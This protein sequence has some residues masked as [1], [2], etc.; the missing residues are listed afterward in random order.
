MINKEKSNNFYKSLDQLSQKMENIN[1]DIE[2][3]KK[4][5]QN[6]MNIMI[7]RI[8]HISTSVPK[9]ANKDFVKHCDSVVKNLKESLNI[10]SKKFEEIL[11]KEEFRNEFKDSFLV[12]IYGKVKAGKSSFGNYIAKQALPSQKAK[13]FLYDKA[14]QIK[15]TAK[16]EEIDSDS[17]F[18][19]KR[20]EATTEIQGFRLSGLTWIDTPG[21]ASMSPENGELAKEY[22]ESAD[23]I[24]YPISSDAP[25]RSTDI[26]EIVELFTKNKKVNILITKSD[27][28]SRTI[29]NGKIIPIIKNKTKEDRKKQEEYVL[30]SIKSNLPKINQLLIDDNIYSLSTR[31]A[32]IGI[33]T[34]NE[35]LYNES[36][37]DIFYEHMT[38]LLNGQAIQLKT[39]APLDKLK[40]F[41][42]FHII[43]ENNDESC[44]TLKSIQ[45]DIQEIEKKREKAISELEN[46][47]QI[48]IGDIIS[49]VEMEIEKNY[50]KINKNNSKQILQNILQKTQTK[51]TKEVSMEVKKVLEDFD[52]SLMK[53]ELNINPDQFKIED[54][55]STI[56]YDDTEKM[57]K[58]GQIAASST[59]AALATWAIANFWNPTGWIAAFGVAAAEMIAMSATGYIGEKIG[60]SFGETKREKVLI[61]DNKHEILSKLKEEMYKLLEKELQ[62]TQNN[63]IKFYFDPIV[64]FSKQT[65]SIMKK[66]ESDMKGCIK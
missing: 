66:M 15:H 14:G 28:T 22:I 46:I 9:N 34:N 55:F 11:R 2:L 26:D 54:K 59:G 29:D 33:E 38:T 60:G 49:D 63:L 25:G 41:V 4:C 24:I 1:N 31:T 21:L 45:K 17:E 6:S 30:N 47:F 64:S 65:G 56:E 62:N 10:W 27:K 20:T 36:N 44:H 37:L 51:L 40:T 43:G 39:K 32:T 23:L 48:L 19:V 42:E 16:L 3:K 35:Q 58:Y 61:G 13:F 8:E 7:K 57:K 5:L 53:F 18:E 12:I 52:S 50:S